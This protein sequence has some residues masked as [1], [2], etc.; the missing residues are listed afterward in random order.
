MDKEI[1]QSPTREFVCNTNHEI[2]TLQHQIK[3][4]QVDLQIAKMFQVMSAD[5]LA[6]RVFELRAKIYG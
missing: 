3:R 2:R 4:L 6:S 1:R 5:E